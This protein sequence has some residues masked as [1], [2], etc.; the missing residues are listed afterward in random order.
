NNVWYD[1]NNNFILAIGDG[2]PYN[3]EHNASY[4][5]D[6][7]HFTFTKSTPTLAP[8]WGSLYN[9]IQSANKV[10]ITIKS[11]DADDA[12]KTQCIAEAR[13]MRGLAYW[14]LASVWGD[15][16]I[17]DDPTPLVNN[18]IVETNP[19]KDVYEFAIRDMEF[20]AKYLSET[21]PATGRVNRYVA[22]GML[23]R[24]YL[25]F[26][27][28]V[29]SN[30]GANPNCQTRDA[31]YLE[32][33]RKAAEK[34]IG[35]GLFKL[36]D[37]YADL[38]QIKNNNNQ[39]SLFSF[40]WVGGKNGN[41]YQSGYAGFTNSQVSYLA[42]ISVA[43]GGEAWGAWT[44]APYDMIKEYE[45]ADTLRRKA[46]WMGYGDFYPEINTAEG[47]LLIGNTADG[48]YNSGHSPANSC[49][50]VKK[51]VTGN[52]KDN[53]NINVRNSGLDNYVLRYAEVLLNYADAVLGNNE[54]TSD[55]T[56][57]GYFNAVRT[58]AG[59]APKASISYDDLRHER[60][61]EFCLEGRYWYFLLARSYY[62]QQEVINA[63]NSQGR[64]LPPVFLFDAPNN[65]R[66][67]NERDPQPQSVGTVT[68]AT[69]MLPLP[70]SD[71]LKNPKLD[72]DKYPP[73]PYNF[74]EEKITDLF[75]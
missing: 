3:L 54:S 50:N 31:A 45:L 73:V 12:L 49:L 20:A 52:M 6:F 60:R 10:I 62:R 59:L 38:F 64:D 48:G 42:G 23:S 39:E 69:L 27:G 7:A 5:G 30:Y 75:N 9:V 57:L 15:A 14:Y 56:A 63:L 22:F 26:S 2:M 21:S 65:L 41:D 24:F 33:A 43:S 66:L 47:G 8:A 72:K 53:E 51:G 40:Q 55:V 19:K 32:L 74:T 17:S 18:P 28:Y 37:N 34:A 70:E 46:T 67:D 35:S 71:I 58:R 29:A 11:I 13:F 4:F 25:D 44:V 68:A 16:I 61:I 1:F 36:Q